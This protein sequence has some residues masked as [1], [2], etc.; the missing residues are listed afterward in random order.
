MKPILFILSGLPGSG[1][2]TISKYLAKEYNA[3]YLRIDVVEQALRDLCNFPVQ[4]EG[5]RLSYRIAEDNL[6]IGNNVVADS[7]NPNDLTRN[8]WENVAIKNNCKHVN[9]EVIC[10]NKTEHRKRVETRKTEIENLKLPAWDEIIKREYEPWSS[11]RIII[12]TANR[13]TEL[14]VEELFEKIRKNILEK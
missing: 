10:S 4:G 5:Y 6:K 2:S 8:E 9:I 7:C 3:I 11:E 1:K 12:D 13:D 14:C